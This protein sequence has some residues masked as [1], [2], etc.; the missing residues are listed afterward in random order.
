MI[1]VDPALDKAAREFF[2][3]DIEEDRQVPK[4]VQITPRLLAQQQVVTFDDGDFGLGPDDLRARNRNV[5]SAVEDRQD[6][7]VL[8]PQP[9]DR[10]DEALGVESNRRALARAQAARVEHAI[11]QMKAVHWNQGRAGSQMRRQLLRQGGLATAWRPRHGDQLAPRLGP[12]RFDPCG[13]I[14]EYARRDQVAISSFG[15]L[16][17]VMKATASDIE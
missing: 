17:P 13:Q 6:H 5:A 7:L 11:V 8:G 2:I 14:V 10:V 3:W 1:V 12:N 15:R 9:P 16:A 4:R